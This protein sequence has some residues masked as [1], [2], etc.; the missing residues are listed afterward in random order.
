M[1]ARVER[2]IPLRDRPP[3]IFR[4]LPLC[5]THAHS[6]WQGARRRASP[7]KLHCMS[8]RLPFGDGH[9]SPGPLC[10]GPFWLC[11]HRRRL[12]R[13]AC[14]S[15][16]STICKAEHGSTYRLSGPGPT[17]LHRSATNTW[18][19]TD[20]T[21]YLIWTRRS[22]PATYRSTRNSIQNRNGSRVD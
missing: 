5:Q 10:L 17:G 14:T 3:H 18:I 9:H 4:D 16:G 6:T 21:R 15:A 11:I 13:A 1:K 20:T 12:C 2:N 7:L 8:P 22:E 19:C